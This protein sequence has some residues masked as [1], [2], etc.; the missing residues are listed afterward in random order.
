[1]R[2]LA[3]RLHFREHVVDLPLLSGS[4]LLTLEAQTWASTVIVVSSIFA[5]WLHSFQSD[6]SSTYC[7][8]KTEV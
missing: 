6:V 3:E 8:K 5:S 2:N 7:M 1:M 4:D